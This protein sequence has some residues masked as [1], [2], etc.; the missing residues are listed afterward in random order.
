MKTPMA[1]N[2]I[3]NPMAKDFVIHTIRTFKV[4]KEDAFT[5]PFPIKS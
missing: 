2:L 5:I 4:L 3:G 1:H